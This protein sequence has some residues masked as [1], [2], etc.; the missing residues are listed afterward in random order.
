[1]N[2]QHQI[3]LSRLQ[4]C[5]FGIDDSNG[6]EEGFEYFDNRH[7]IVHNVLHRAL[8]MLLTFRNERY[9][10]DYCESDEVSVPVSVT[11]LNI[12]SRRT[13]S[14]GKFSVNITPSSE[15]NEYLID[16]PFPQDE[17]SEFCNYRVVVRDVKAKTVLGTYDLGF[18]SEEDEFERRL[19]AF[20]ASELAST[21]DDDDAKTEYSN[22]D[23]AMVDEPESASEVEPESTATEELPEAAEADS[24]EEPLSQLSQE[25]EPLSKMVGLESVKAKLSVYR[26]VVRFNRMRR[27]NH[28]PVFSTPLHAMFLGSPGT[29][30]TTV[31]KYIGKMLADAGVLS[32]GHV[33]VKERATLCGQNYNSESEKTVAAIEEAQGGILLIDEAYQLYQPNDPRDPGKFVIETLL[34]A[35]ADESKR[36]WMLIL[37]GYS[38][39]MLRM[40]DMNP[41]LRSRIPDSNIYQ[42][43]DFT[44]PQ[45]MEIAENYLEQGQYRLSA[46][47]RIALQNRLHGDFI[48]RDSNFGNARH[49]MNLLQ[50]EVLTNMAI[51]VTGE[52]L[53]PSD[54]VLT[55]IQAEDIPSHSQAPAMKKANRAGFN[56]A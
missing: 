39:P 36:D 50:T 47:A 6:N 31:A 12:T 49:V 29:G 35:L 25:E 30:K 44:E 52:W 48:N 55:L 46:D 38:E 17:I 10:A 15:E 33:V 4:V 20:I 28:L 14:S 2:K 42:F 8:A 5:P 56:V 54:E 37:A 27:L 24:E 9:C 1:M 18:Y 53:R 21:S 3:S 32:S 7:E 19:S 45:L 13:I 41:G 26:K 11:I 34:T 22:L 23:W 43:D 16:L 51:R 40:F